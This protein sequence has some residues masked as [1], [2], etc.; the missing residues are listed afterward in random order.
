MPTPGKSKAC[1]LY[2]TPVSRLLCSR[3]MTLVEV[4]I[5][6]AI[7]AIGIIGIMGIQGATVSNVDRSRG[8]LAARAL[9]LSKIDDMQRLPQTAADLAPCTGSM[10]VYG[11]GSGPIW[12]HVEAGASGS[13]PLNVANPTGLA[14]NSVALNEQGLVDGSVQGRYRRYWHV[15]SPA[16]SGFPNAVNVRVRVEWRDL[17]VGVTVGKTRFITYETMLVF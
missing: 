5:A 1:Q 13:H 12:C 3:G 14:S 8:Q 15:E 10:A 17:D 16:A 9:A 4:M 2:G 6:A 11:N 7:L